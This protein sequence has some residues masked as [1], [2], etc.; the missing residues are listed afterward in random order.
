MHQQ[1]AKFL[2]YRNNPRTL[3][4]DYLE[5]RIEVY[6]YTYKHRKITSKHSVAGVPSSVVGVI[7]TQEWDL[8]F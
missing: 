6:I 8:E 1:Y 3:L 4:T 5:G 2:F 7:E